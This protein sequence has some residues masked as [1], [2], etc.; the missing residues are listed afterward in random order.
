MPTET[1]TREVPAAALEMH[2]GQFEF[3]A[4]GDDPKK[5]KIKLTARSGD[6]IRH[7]Y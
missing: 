5:T 1:T 7:W 3:A 4:A 6:P 2:L